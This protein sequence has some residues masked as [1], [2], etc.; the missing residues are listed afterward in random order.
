MTTRRPLFG[1]EGLVNNP[2]PPQFAPE[3]EEMIRA[4]ARLGAEE[5]LSFFDRGA[6]RGQAG[7]LAAELP[8]L[9]RENLSVETNGTVH[10]LGTHIRTLSVRACPPGTIVVRL[11]GPDNRTIDLPAQ[12]LH[13]DDAPIARAQLV[14]AAAGLVG[15]A[16]V[17]LS[18]LPRAIAPP[19]C[20]DGWISYFAREAG[21]GNAAPA[22]TLPAGF[23]YEIEG[24]TV[25]CAND[26]T[27]ATRNVLVAAFPPDAVATDPPVAHS[28]I[29]AGLTASQ[30]GLLFLGLG[31]GIFRHSDTGVDPIRPA[32]SVTLEQYF[33]H[34]G[35][36]WRGRIASAAASPNFASKVGNGVAGD[37]VLMFVSGRRRMI[38]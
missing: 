5:A 21:V 11:F 26:A 25:H 14:V 17:F 4:A 22:H 33:V 34:G 30:Q 31:N 8:F 2:P 7:T 9:F 1:P 10:E 6:P 16:D 28:S 27:V 13:I 32:G 29:D 38:R 36:A 19:C 37:A 35:P 18:S 12:G 15:T 23:E 20:D 24:V 3:Q